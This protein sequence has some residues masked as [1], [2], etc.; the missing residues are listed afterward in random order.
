M[1]GTTIRTVKHKRVNGS[2]YRLIRRLGSGAEGTAFLAIT[3]SGGYVV[4]KSTTLTAI[5]RSRKTIQLAETTF[6]GYIRE[7]KLK[8][9]Y[10]ESE[11]INVS[12]ILDYQIKDSILYQIK[13]YIPGASSPSRTNTIFNILLDSHVYCGTRLFFPIRTPKWIPS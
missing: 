7:L 10:L 8:L 1:Q 13:E 3:D 6:E 11:G 5:N 12:Q 9:N 4:L 2:N